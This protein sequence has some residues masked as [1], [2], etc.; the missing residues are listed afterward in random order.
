MYIKQI[1]VNEFHSIYEKSIFYMQL[2]LFFGVL[3]FKM[4]VRND[5]K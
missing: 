2:F 3:L 5:F 1:S 4:L